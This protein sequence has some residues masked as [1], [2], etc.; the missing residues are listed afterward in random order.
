MT[1]DTG[2]AED[3]HGLQSP[4]IVVALSRMDSCYY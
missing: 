2:D 1:S 3:A 4:L